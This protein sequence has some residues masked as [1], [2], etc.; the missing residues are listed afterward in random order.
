MR[1]RRR[2]ERGVKVAAQSHGRRG[3]DAVA[4]KLFARRWWVG[5]CM[6]DFRISVK[7]SRLFTSQLVHLRDFLKKKN[8]CIADFFA[9]RLACQFCMS[10]L[11]CR[12]CM[13]VCMSSVH[14]RF[15][16]ILH[17]KFCM[18]SFAW[19]TCFASHLVHGQHLPHLVFCVANTFRNLIF[20]VAKV[21]RISSS[22]S[23]TCSSVGI[24]DM[25]GIAHSIADVGVAHV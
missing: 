16:R 12:L 8:F 14:V 24:A 17:V 19:P 21:F 25:M 2:R 13:S 9:C 15:A 5:G 18:S 4:W 7:V 3:F 23:P 10:T 11:P 22:A 1:G 20:C 6:G